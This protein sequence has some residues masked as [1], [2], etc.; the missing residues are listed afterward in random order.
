MR[1]DGADHLI[2]S[3]GVAVH[4]NIEA[5]TVARDAF[6]RRADFYLSAAGAHSA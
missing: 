6:D 3:P 2:E 4:M 1:R 5:T